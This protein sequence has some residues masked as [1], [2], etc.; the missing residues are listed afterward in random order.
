MK[1]NELTPEDKLTISIQV[2]GKMM[3]YPTS[4]A[5]IADDTVF[6]EPIE[7]GGKKLSFTSDNISVNLIHYNEND[8][9]DIWRGVK[10]PM[11]ERKGQKYYRCTNKMNSIKL[12][13]RSS[14]R[15]FVGEKGTAQIGLSRNGIDV[16]VKDISEDSFAFIVD[17]EKD[18][19]VNLAAPVRLIFE[20]DD[21]KFSL[22]G[23]IVR[24]DEKLIACRLTIENKQI[25]KFIAYKQRVKMN[26]DAR[27]NRLN[28]ADT[29]EE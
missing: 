6:L 13:R 20:V 10:L 9:P 29:K 16:L 15:M 21:Y 4:V 2:S 22:F 12:N 28:A 3:E 27:N 5:E 7:I 8:M 1:I 25:S 26:L 14:Y 19:Q 17:S 23:S 18:A 24:I 11:V